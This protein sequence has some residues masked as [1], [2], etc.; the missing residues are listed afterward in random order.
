M[1]FK[2]LLVEHRGRVSWVYLNRPQALN[3]IA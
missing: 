1:T 3:A 2:H